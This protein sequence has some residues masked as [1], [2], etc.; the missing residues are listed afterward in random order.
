MSLSQTQV[1]QSLAEALAWFEKELGWGVAPAELNHLTGRIGELYA[2]MITRGQMA[3]ET[4]QRGYDVISADNERISVKTVTSSVHVSFNPNTFDQVDRVMV[5]RV[6]VDE[7]DGVSVETLLDCSAA[8]FL[9]KHGKDSGKHVFGTSA[10][11]RPKQSLDN[12]QV[13][14]E[15]RWG[16]HLVRQFENGTIQVLISGNLQQMAKPHLREI[17][18]EIGVDLLNSNSRAK[19]TR[20]LGAD[21]IKVLQVKNE[22]RLPE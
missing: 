9:E 15:A 19:N 6:N 13:S 2:A 8:E 7:E 10:G 4:N 5:L 3:L 18:A 11:S 1:I 22:K 16:D 14:D 17:A 21:I 20:Q 12:L